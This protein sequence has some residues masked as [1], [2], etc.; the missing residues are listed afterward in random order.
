[1]AV[2]VMFLSSAPEKPE[3]V[4]GCATAV[5]PAEAQQR[6]YQY[7]RLSRLLELAPCC[8]EVLPTNTNTL[9]C[10][11]NDTYLS[12]WHCERNAQWNGGY[13]LWRLLRARLATWAAAVRA[14]ARGIA[15]SIFGPPPMMCMRFSYR[16]LI[17]ISRCNV[18]SY[19]I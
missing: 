1:V 15:M 10:P 3:V 5:V 14:S 18:F 11:P 13:L 17:N 9:P 6:L 4:W 7:V 12:S 19:F 8:A 16:S 2:L